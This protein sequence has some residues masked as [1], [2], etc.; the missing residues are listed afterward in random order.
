[1]QISS[2]VALVTL[3]ALSPATNAA[4]EEPE[5]TTKTPIES[6]SI[7][8]KVGQLMIWTFSGSEFSPQIQEM[9]GK[10]QLGALIAFSRNIPS[11]V[12][13]A[14]FNAQAQAFANKHLKAPLMLMVDQE[15]GT[16]T[17]VRVNTPIPSALA[18]GRM[19]NP[20]FAEDYA[21]MNAELLATLGFNVNLSPVLDVS[22]PNTDTFMANRV[23]GDDPHLVMETGLATAKGISES[24]VL[25]VGK[26]FPGHGGHVKDSH[27]GTPSKTA[28]LEELEQ[29]DLIPFKN[30]IAADFPRAIM[31]AHLSL[32]KIDPSGIPATYSQKII[33]NILR[34]KYGYKGLIITDDLE[35][36]GASIS[37]SLGERAVRAFLAGNDMLMLAGHPRNQ[38]IAFEAMIKAVKAGRISQARLDE[39][40]ERI[41]QVK[42]Q[43]KPVNF[44][45]EQERIRDVKTKIE[46]MSR[47]VI[48]H[49]FKQSTDGQTTRFPH[50]SPNTKVTVFASDPR[51]LRM[52]KQKFAGHGRLMR[53]TSKNLEKVP[54]EIQNNGT[55]FAIFYA[56]GATTARWVQRL[57]EQ[58]KVKTL[59]VN[60][61][62]PGKIRRQT[63]FISVLNINSPSPESGG[64]LAEILSKPVEPRAPAAAPRLIEPNDT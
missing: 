20:T 17:R 33:Q 14:K 16:V 18:L 34:E 36:N 25:P 29:R 2:F 64:W 9:L 10:Y 42:N 52:F 30:F 21:K 46:A 50:I 12:Q 58:L 59:V 60:C 47:E 8:Q 22:D 27:K 51:F 43:I 1:L 39:S 41:L 57:N 53:L 63:D 55:Q 40:V 28:T 7:E 49:N 15:G 62:N 32:P 54:Q 3:L 56:S 5:R 23:F 38:K 11:S 24:G 35:M 6:M 37:P 4:N 19:Q 44:K 45:F 61:N 31:M 48:E 13:I 26:H